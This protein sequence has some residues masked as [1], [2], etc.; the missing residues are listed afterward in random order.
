[1]QQPKIK[2]NLT[3]FDK[4]L[5]VCALLLLIGFWSY[6][7]FHYT[8]LP[9]TI[10]THFNGTGEVN[11]YGNKWTILTLPLMTTLL[12]MFLTIVV[13]FPHKFNYPFTLTNENAQKSYTLV[14]RMMRIMK[15]II[16]IVFFSIEYKTIQIAI[17]NAEDAR[18][19]F[20][21]TI[22]GLV[23]GWIFYFLISMSKNQ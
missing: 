7:L 15:L 17:G 16:V 8:N 11:G 6:T 19:W 22:F 5:E 3:F 14:T 1:M 13:N 10:P 18:K 4:T 2:I 9:D 21:L 23:F 12:F 20:L